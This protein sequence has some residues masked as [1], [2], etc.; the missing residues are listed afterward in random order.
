MFK[1]CWH[2]VEW[3]LEWWCC[4]SF[5]R[6]QVSYQLQCLF[7]CYT[8]TCDS[9]SDLLTVVFSTG[10]SAGLVGSSSWFSEIQSSTYGKKYNTSSDSHGSC[11][12]RYVWIC[13]DLQRTLNTN[14]ELLLQLESLQVKVW[15][16]VLLKQNI[17]QMA[18]MCVLRR[19]QCKRLVT[20]YQIPEA[21]WAAHVTHVSQPT[22]L[23]HWSWQQ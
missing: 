2:T 1:P 7:F 21:P 16:I 19:W 10:Q 22:A 13:F 3:L 4:V 8:E 14:L 11:A 12:A 23:I 18:I 6:E 5:L 17:W 20:R 15:S 9:V